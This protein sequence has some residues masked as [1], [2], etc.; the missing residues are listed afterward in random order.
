MGVLCIKK[1]NILKIEVF[2]KSVKD[3]KSEVLNKDFK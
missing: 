1:N 2:Y 3:I